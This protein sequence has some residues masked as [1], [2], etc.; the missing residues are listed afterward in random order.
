MWWMGFLSVGLAVHT[1]L[2]FVC[3]AVFTHGP[4]GPRPRAANFQGRHIKKKIE[5]ETRYAEKKGLSTREKFKG[6]LY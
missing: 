6:D 2:L 1:G 5:I 3:I 4:Q